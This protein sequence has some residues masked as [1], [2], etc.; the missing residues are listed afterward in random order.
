MLDIASVLDGVDVE[1]SEIV[2]F[3]MVLDLDNTRAESGHCDYSPVFT[4]PDSVSGDKSN[5]RVRQIRAGPQSP[6]SYWLP[7]LS[8]HVF[9]K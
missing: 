7:R 2:A 9:P 4:R 8:L 5:S 1:D 6:P 3:E